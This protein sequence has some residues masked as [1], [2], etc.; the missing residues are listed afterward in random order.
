MQTAIIKALSLQAGIVLSAFHSLHDQIT[1][2]LVQIN[3]L[4]RGNCY[5]PYAAGLLQ[6]YIQAHAATPQNFEFLLPLYKPIKTEQA[7]KHL[8]T[9]QIVGFSCYTWN[10]QRSLAIAAN[11]KLQQPNTLIIMGGPQ[12][13]DASEAFLREHPFID[14]CVHGP[15]E[16]IFLA[17]LENWPLNHWEHIPGISYLTPDGEYINHPKPPRVAD[18]NHIPSPYL[19]GVFEPLLP[20]EHSHMWIG[21][22]ETNRGCPFS[23]TFCDWGSAV[24]SKVYPFALERLNAE[25]HW[26][27]QHKIYFVFCCDANFGI[28]SRDL[29]ITDQ[30]I[31]LSKHYGYPKAYAFQD[32]KNA[33]E[34]AYEIDIKLFKANLMGDVTLSLQTL[35]P[36]TLKAIR[37]ENISLKSYREKQNRFV[38]QGIRAYTDIIIGLPGD[39]FDSFADTVATVIEN[40]QHYSIKFYNLGVLPNAQLADPAYMAAHGV[41]TITS[42]Y[43]YLHEPLKPPLDGIWEYEK[44]VIATATMPRHDWIRSRA[45]AWMVNLLYFEGHVL[46]VV[47]LLL[48]HCYGVSLKT[49]LLA[50]L[51]VMPEYPLLA[52]VRDFFLQKAQSIQDG[53]TEYCPAPPGCSTLE[54]IALAAYELILFELRAQGDIEQ[55][56]AEAK[57]LL[58]QLLQEQHIFLS[59]DL[60]DD[61]LSCSEA[62]CRLYLR[63]AQIHLPLRY[64]VWDVYQQALVSHPATI[65]PQVIEYYKDWPGEPLYL[66]RR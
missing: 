33:T 44:L 57:Q 7:V 50:F 55:F 14:V 45:L 6:A 53:D 12:V 13:P 34:R 11:L 17:L 48:F 1:V 65:E 8:L 31:A 54:G 56:Y 46:Q 38:Q 64:N 32:A 20:L 42:R 47:L 28:L 63:D 21:L 26:F 61:M 52:K 62:L 39:T 27:G 5:L 41:E 4:H 18:L 40:G 15:G 10:M 58:T 22:W 51:D 30:V 25:I 19:S 9:A 60:L 35:A 37:R 24:Q 66:L 43:V 16:A 23:C 3:N 29:E 36:E 59:A 2:G 49:M